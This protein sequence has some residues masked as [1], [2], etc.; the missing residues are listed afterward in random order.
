MQYGMFWMLKYNNW[1]VLYDYTYQFC[2]TDFLCE[3]FK[4]VEM[5]ESILHRIIT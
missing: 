5:K 2:L 1:F 3:I 4:V